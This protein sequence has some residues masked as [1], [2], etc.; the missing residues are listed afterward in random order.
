M[1]IAQLREKVAEA[2]YVWVRV[3]KDGS[4]VEV[5][6]TPGG[7]ETMTDGSMWWRFVLANDVRRAINEFGDALGASVSPSSQKG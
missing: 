7:P 3:A 5:R 2:R 6:P 4:P 1:D